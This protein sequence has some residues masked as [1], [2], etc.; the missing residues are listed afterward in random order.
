MI[1]IKGPW[2]SITDRG[3]WAARGASFAGKVKATKMVWF[4][5][6]PA[7][8][9]EQAAS[10]AKKSTKRTTEAA[11]KTTRAA[12]KATGAKPA[13]RA[14]KTAAGGAKKATT[15]VAGRKK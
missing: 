8:T 10:T 9:G 13:T 3:R 6:G 2:K 14:T 12:K 15:P 5:P 11:K 1:E 7:E 4:P